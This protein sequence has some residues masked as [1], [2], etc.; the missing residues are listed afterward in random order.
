MSATVD[1]GCMKHQV[2]NKS[3]ILLGIFCQFILLP[4]LGFAVV[5]LL[6]LEPSI[7]ITLLV[8]TSSPGGSY[9]NWWCSMFNADLALSVTM[10]AISTMVS[11]LALPANLLLYANISYQRDVTSD[12]D[13][14]SVFVA[15]AIVIAAISLG[16]MCSY[17]CHSHRFNI[18]ANQIGNAAGLCLII[19]SATMTN[20]GEADTK[21]WS[22]HWTFYVSVLVPCVLGLAVASML[23]SLVNLRKPE[24][25]TV[26]I[27]CGYQNVG[28]ATSLA[29]TMFNGEELKNAMGIPFFYGVCEMF[30]V[31]IYCVGCWKAGWTKAP[32]NA[33]LWTVLF[34]TFE[35]LEAEMKELTE[36]E[37]SVSESS[38]D[39]STEKS[40]DREENGV[41]THYFN[42][43]DTTAGQSSPKIP[44]G[45]IPTRSPSPPST[46][47]KRDFS[48][49]YV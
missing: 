32:A 38:S 12:L 27:E 43:T 44:S 4:F 26:A 31:G 5:N 18:I 16:L 42:W 11:V 24:R 20:T 2:R 22:R 45:I 13:W 19:F 28:I 39:G 35:V 8:V 36:I 10:T 49:A 23:A 47:I 1:I 46:S 17:Y 48:D 29:L 37:V 3:A 25:M 6:N 21:I 40:A 34:T 41:L 7:G 9:S 15:L 33:S 14:A 30:V